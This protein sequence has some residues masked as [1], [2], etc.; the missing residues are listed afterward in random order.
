MRGRTTA[1]KGSSGAPQFG[2]LSFSHATVPSEC[3]ANHLAA[4]AFS[5]KKFKIIPHHSPHLNRRT[6]KEL[7]EVKATLKDTKQTKLFWRQAWQGRR[8]HARL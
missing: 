1:A 8:R 7:H 5:R 2:R 6:D 4:V 3:W